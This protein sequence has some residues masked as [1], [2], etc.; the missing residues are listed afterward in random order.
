MAELTIEQ[1]RALALAAARLRLQQQADPRGEGA[2]ASAIPGDEAMSGGG[3]EAALIGARQ[4]VTLGFGDEINAGVRAGADWLK[5][6]IGMGEPTEFGPAYDERL[7]HERALLGQVRDENPLAATGGEIAGA[8]LLPGGVAGAGAKGMAAAGAATGAAYG[9]GDAEGGLGERAKGAAVGGVVGGAL[10]AA[11][12]LVLGK[13]QG[14]LTGRAERKA[15]DA[16]ARAA[17][18]ADELRATAGAI[19][20]GVEKRGVAIR[21]ERFA[22]LVEDIAKATREMGIDRDLTPRSVAALRRLVD[23]VDTPAES[24]SWKDLETLRRVTSIASTAKDPADRRVAGA[25]V[26]KVDDF[27]MNLVDGDLTAGKAE[28]LSDELKQARALWKRMRGSERISGAMEAAKDAAS[29]YENGLRIEFRK[30]IKDAKFF[31]GLSTQEQDAIRQVV[32]GTTVGNVLKRVSRLSFGTGAQ[33]NFLGA[34]VGS[35][36]A[37]AAGNAIAGPVGGMIG[38]VAAPLAGRVAGNAAEQATVN[39]ARRAQGL[40]AAGPNALAATAPADVSG[41]GNALARLRL[42]VAGAASDQIT[43]WWSPAQPA[44]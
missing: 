28:G 13:V 11:T 9:F 40:I 23:A 21:M 2:A 26:A 17:P 32:Q 35:G 33:T 15:V 5:G 34:S 12:P 39:A 14:A 16:V 10:G 7:K 3:I 37:A 18:G 31:R 24:I 20:D 6:K 41:L 42:P 43:G 8:M 25:I 4:G 1:K 38:A 36:A 27:V 22:P 19:Y 29:G 30:L 44:R